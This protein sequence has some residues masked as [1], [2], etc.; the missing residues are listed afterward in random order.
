MGKLALLS[1]TDRSINW[2]NL[3]GVQSEI[4]IKNKISIS[5]NCIL[6]GI[7]SKEVNTKNKNVVKHQVCSKMKKKIEKNP[8]V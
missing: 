1:L 5:F 6:L 7:Y 4:N 3:C 8:E 2:Y